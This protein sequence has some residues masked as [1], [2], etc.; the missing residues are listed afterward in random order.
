MTVALAQINWVAVFIATIIYSAFSGI[1][2]RQFA[3]GK[4]WERAM[5]FDRPDGWKETS[6]YFVIP[7]FCCLITSTA[8]AILLSLVKAATYVDAFY[9]G[10]VVGVGIATAVTLT[11]S[12]IPT[13]KRPMVFGAITG[14]AHAISIVMAT[15]VIYA[16]SK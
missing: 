15:I 16:M 1:W 13:M 8:I 14:T 3:F 9:L 7:F 2:H 10:I 11:N 4:I 6:L 12:V 5:G